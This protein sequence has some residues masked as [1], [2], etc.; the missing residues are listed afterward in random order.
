MAFNTLGGPVDTPSTKTS[1]FFYQPRELSEL[2]GK[3]AMFTQHII[4]SLKSH[5][6]GTLEGLYG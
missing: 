6:L 3:A 4:H 2:I 5:Y 1:L